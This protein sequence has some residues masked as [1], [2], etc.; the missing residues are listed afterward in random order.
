MQIKDIV[1]LSTSAFAAVLCFVLRFLIKPQSEKKKK[2]KNTLTTL[3]TVAAAWYF[4]GTLLNILSGRDGITLSIPDLEMFS[5]RVEIFGISLA[6]TTV[7]TYVMI[8]VILLFALC[9]RIFAVPKFKAEKPTGI[10][11]VFE[12]LQ[13]LI[14]GFVKSVIK[15]ELGDGITSFMYTVAVF[16]MGCALCELFG[17]RAPTSDL[18]TTLSLAL[19]TFFLINYCGIKQKGI[20]GRIKFL[21]SP[22]PILFPMKVLSDC[23][24]PVSLACR[25]FGNML[26]G[27]IVMELLRASLGGYS[28]GLSSLLGIY[29]NLAHPLIQT[30]V[31]IVLSLTFINEAA[32]DAEE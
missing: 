21:A 19:C 14:D 5:D 30:Y 32:E 25:L 26:G 15:V 17:Q 27:L 13:E 2:R 11:N 23:A 6:R 29:F 16:M 24:V 9:F 4:V 1:A 12:A 31:F 18:L 3:G 7:V 20:F 22:S 8:G 28:A 10:Q